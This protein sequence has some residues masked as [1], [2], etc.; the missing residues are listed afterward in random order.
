M[1]QVFFDDVKLVLH[2]GKMLI[3]A[4]SPAH[5]KEE[6]KNSITT[7]SM[8]S[9]PISV[10]NVHNMYNMLSIFANMHYVQAHTQRH[11]VSNRI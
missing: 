1:S 2:Y 5:I 9:N 8:C 10:K 3:M 6:D 4:V 11:E 7:Y